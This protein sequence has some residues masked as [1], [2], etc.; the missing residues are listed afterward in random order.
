MRMRITFSK[1]AAMRYTGHLDLH[2][3]WE[4]SMR[5]AGL[6]LA[7]SQGFNPHP[8]INLASALPLGFTGEGEV[9]DIWLSEAQ[10][11]LEVCQKL[12]KAL[13]PGIHLHEL[14]VV[15]DRL[16]SLQSVMHASE[17]VVTFLEP[18]PD[19][20][21]H[22]SALLE[23][24]SLP[25]ERRG[26][27]YDLRALLLALELLPPDEDGRQRMFVR[28]LAQEGATG[29]PEEVILA[30]EGQPEETRVHRTRLLF[31]S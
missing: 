2:R 18:L 25:R 7:Y 30:L 9:V 11:E 13:P 14:R 10:D 3:T 27:P 23:A 20:H 21:Q 6:P 4:R 22:V 26:K 5:R 28:L 19:L 8:R 24:D 15:E 17:Y 29:R 16:P 12:H 31:S 1:N